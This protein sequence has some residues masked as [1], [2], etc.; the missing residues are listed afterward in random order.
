[1]K[2]KSRRR[3]LRVRTMALGILAMAG[4]FAFVNRYPSAF[5]TVE[6]RMDD[7]RMYTPA[8]RK[9]LGIVAIAAIDDKSIASF[10]RWP[11]PRERIAQLVS[12]L[13]DYGVKVVGLDLVLSESETEQR[14]SLTYSPGEIAR[15]GGITEPS[16]GDLALAKAITR[17]GA[18]FVGTP[19]RIEGDPHKR[20]SISSMEYPPAPSQSDPMRYT[21]VRQT[22]EK[23]PNVVNAGS[24]LAP[25]P[26]ISR[27]ARGAGFVNIEPDEDLVVRS[28][29]MVVRYHGQYFV[30]LSLALVSAYLEQA[31]LMLNLGENGVKGI[32][33]GNSEAPVDESGHMVIRFRG[34][35]GAFPLY[36][37][38]DLIARRVP[39]AELAG[40][41]VLVG[42]ASAVGLGDVVPTPTGELLPGVE[43]H[44]TL[45]DDLLSHDFV[46]R[47][48][49][50]AAEEL[51]A[52]ILLTAAA[53]FCVT[54]LSA[55][56]AGLGGIVLAGGYLAYAQYRLEVDRVLLGVVIPTLAIVLTYTLLA[57]Y[58]YFSE[59]SERQHLRRLFEYYLHPDVIAEMADNPKGIQLGGQR[60][61]L[62]ILFADI[63][64]FTARAERTEPEA[65]VDMLY[66]YMTEMTDAIMD[67]RGVVDKMMGDG[68]MAFWGAPLDLPNPAKSAID[69]AIAMLGRL[70]HLR[71]KDPRFADLEI[72]I[73]VH[74]GDAV[75][76]NFGGARRFDYSVI[77]DVVN[78]ASRLEALTRHFGVRLL[79][80]RQAYQEA[81]GSYLAREIGLVR[82][83]G[84]SQAVA[85]FEVVA[86]QSASD[87][88]FKR[89]SAAV[90]TV[91]TGAERVALTQFENL[92]EE[93]PG[94]RIAKLWIAKLRTEAAQAGTEHIFEFDTK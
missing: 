91:D 93:K 26:V 35:A 77:G 31:P 92:L 45:I 66:A 40:R 18:V 28:A 21:I 24:Y 87:D 33:V 8:T 2:Q 64:N 62:A 25:L 55:A 20:N 42:E 38:V 51:L 80:S 86:D 72:G 11:W 1:M 44:A 7:L 27:A 69:C 90:S 36:S 82:V 19:F 17:Q 52:S 68:I 9:S 3:N 94:D 89:F 14:G 70:D 79:V 88:F 46:S 13:D 34:A 57:S 61:H 71:T 81:D 4:I 85:I 39:R 32:S 58:R 59:G 67:S 47:S 50:T 65:L 29:L 10:G 49:V 53:V 22:A 75:V 43:V 73:G 5:R 78:I 60:R 12:A 63:V 56:W 41:I 74:V 23:I 16:S 76:G 48:S 37:A 54:Y 15:G 6:L 84:K 83:K 30:P